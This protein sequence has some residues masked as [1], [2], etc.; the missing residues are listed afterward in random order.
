MKQE[1]RH[2][3]SRGKWH[4]RLECNLLN[5]AK[6]LH[7]E[8]RLNAIDGCSGV[9]I[10]LS[11][12]KLFDV[13]F[14]FDHP[15]LKRWMPTK[16]TKSYS[17]QRIEEY[18]DMP[19]EKNIGVS[20]H[21][22]TFWWS[23]WE[24]S[25]E[26]SRRQPWWWGGSF[27]PKRFL[28]G[29]AKHSKENEIGVKATITMPEGEYKVIGSQYTSVWRRSRWPIPKRLKRFDIE[30]EPPI[31]VPGKGENSWDLDD[32]AIFGATIAGQTIEEILNKE[33]DSILNIRERYSGVDW[34]PDDGWTVGATD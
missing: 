26:W 12:R 11:I 3:W 25:G 23:L 28:L 9:Q 8:I 24:T 14:T 2:W 5:D 13:W 34:I 32:D 17:R 22:R 18:W 30:F 21:S 1:N 29:K 4:F 20:W 15:S 33:R 7:A 19:I 31:P 6:F 10:A 27:D 16:R